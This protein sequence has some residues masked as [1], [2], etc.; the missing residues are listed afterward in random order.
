MYKFDQ[1]KKRRRW[2]AVAAAAA[3]VLLIAPTAY[4]GITN[5]AYAA[6]LPIVGD[7][8]RFL[9]NGRTGAYDLYQE[10]AS[11]LNMTQ[12]DQGIAITINEAVFDGQ[13]IYYT[14]ELISDDDLGEHPYIGSASNFSVKGYFGG[15]AGSSSELVK[16]GD[17][18][19]VGSS[20]CSL[21]QGRDKIRCQLDIREIHIGD[22]EVIKGRW[23]FTLSLQAVESEVQVV[24]QSVAL[25]GHMVTIDSLELAPMSF[26]INY[27]QLLAEQYR[28]DEWGGSITAEIAIRD[29]LGNVYHGQSQGG[30]GNVETGELSWRTTFGSLIPGATKLVIMPSL[31]YSSGSGGGVMIDRYGNETPLENK[32][33]ELESH[34]EF[35]DEIVVELE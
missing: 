17:G 4:I 34:R 33:V 14:Y 20:S 24:N 21:D 11:E 7:I 35:M 12:V 2:A 19:Y 27:T 16:V 6:E 18:Q 29:N 23:C 25:D 9:D 31:Y 28:D 13:T 5:P 15:I 10:N 26:S 1:K 3:M 32:H 22:D 30:H 8:F